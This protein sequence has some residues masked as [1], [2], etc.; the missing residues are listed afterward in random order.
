MVLTDDNFASIVSAIEQG[1][2]IYANIRKFV[3]FLLACNVG[4]ILIV[5]G[6]MLVGLPMPL[7]PV[8]LLW[9][10]LVS[11]GA[12][13]LALGMEKGDDDIMRQP[14][15]SAKEPVINRDMALG[16]AV[17]GVVDMLAILTVFWLAMQRYPGH[18]EAAQTIAFVTLC[19]SELIRAFAAR[20]EIHSVFAI[21]VF[22]NRWMV[23][24]VTVSFCLVLA[25]VYLPFL[26]PFFD[27]VPPSVD[28][29]L[30]MLPFFFASP[31][32]MELLKIHIRRRQRPAP[33]ES[34]SAVMKVHTP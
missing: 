15:R 30:L 24:A 14:A 11:D 21:G 18:L 27:A 6:A 2:I 1:R 28:D 34:R 31:I 13:A 12:P 17:V 4:E 19:T 5:F 33:V 23:A 8:Q 29:W 9:L 32:A 3:Y 7:R 25:V 16:I 22:S 10:N 20:S 26:A